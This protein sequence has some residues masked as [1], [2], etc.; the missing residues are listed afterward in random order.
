MIVVD[1]RQ[2]TNEYTAAEDEEKGEELE[3]EGGT[4]C[5]PTW[6]EI[7]VA[8][9]ARGFF[10]SLKQMRDCLIVAFIKSHSRVTAQ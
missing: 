4:V 9:C 3:E 6:G 5:V 8:L 2:S 10:L 1:H 7:D